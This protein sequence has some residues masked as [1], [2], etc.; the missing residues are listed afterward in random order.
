MLEELTSLKASSVRQLLVY[1]AAVGRKKRSGVTQ[2]LYNG[3]QLC[4]IHPYLNGEYF[5]YFGNQCV[6]I[7]P[8]VGLVKT[9]YVISMGEHE[10]RLDTFFSH[11]LRLL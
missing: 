6:E 1:T 9:L 4:C 2:A 3:L 11:L 7:E 10:F 8:D 5:N